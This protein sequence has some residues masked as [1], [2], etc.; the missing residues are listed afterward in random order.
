MPMY[1]LIEYSKIYSK[2]SGSLRN[3]YRD[4]PSDPIKDSELSLRQALQ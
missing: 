4:E 2:T 3:Y 1:S